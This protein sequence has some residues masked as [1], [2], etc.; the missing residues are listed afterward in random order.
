MPQKLAT[1]TTVFQLHQPW[2]LCCMYTTCFGLVRLVVRSF[3]FTCTHNSL[4]LEFITMVSYTDEGGSIVAQST[5]TPPT[6]LHVK[7]AGDAL[8]FVMSVPRAS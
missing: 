3:D 2:R 6:E 8:I 4:I 5:N 1:L 7:G